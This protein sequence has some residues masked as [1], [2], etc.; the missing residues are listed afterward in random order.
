M[1]EV[2]FE[3]ISKLSKRIALT[4]Q[5]YEHISQRHPEVKGEIEKMKEA[6]VYSSNHQ[7]KL[8]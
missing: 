1:S 6:L 2:V 4:T 3:V 5:G 8:L 7:E